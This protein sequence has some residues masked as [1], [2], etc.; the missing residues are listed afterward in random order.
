[1]KKCVNNLLV[2]LRLVVLQGVKAGFKWNNAAFRCVMLV[3]MLN[4]VVIHVSGEVANGIGMFSVSSTKMVAFAPGNLQ[5]HPKN[6]EWRFAENQYDIIGEDNKNISTDYDGWID[7]F[8]WSASDGSAK[9]GVSSSENNNDYVG[10]FV[11]WGKNQIGSDAPDTWRTMTMDEWCYLCNTRMKADSLRGLGRINGVAGL[12]LLPDNWTCPVGVT[13]DSY[14]VQRFTINEWSRLEA[15]GAVFLPCAGFRYGSDVNSVNSRPTYWSSTER[16]EGITAYYINLV[17]RKE[18]AYYLY[19]GLSV[20]LVKDVV[21]LDQDTHPIH[22]DTTTTKVTSTLGQTISKAVRINISDLLGSNI[23]I[24]GTSDNSAFEVVALENVSS[25]GQNLIVNYTPTAVTDGIETATIT[26]Y[27]ST[28]EGSTSFTMTGRHV[29]AE[30]AIISKIGDQWY[31]LPSDN[32]NATAVLVSVNDDANPT[33]GVTMAPENVKWSLR[34]PNNSAVD[35]FVLTNPNNQYLNVDAN[36]ALQMNTTYNNCEWQPVIDDLKEYQLTNAGNTKDLGVSQQKIF[37]TL[38]DNISDV[39]RLVS[40]YAETTKGVGVFSVS[41]TKQVT[42]SPGNLQYHPKN[43]EWRFAPSQLDYVGEE[44]NHW[45]NVMNPSYDGW[46][47][48]F[49]WSTEKT[50]FGLSTTSEDYTDGSFVDWGI[51]Q[52]SG[53]APN[54]WR[55]LTNDEWGYILNERPYASSLHGVAQVNGVN[56]LVL[57]PDNW[58]C[59]AGVTFKSG[60]HEGGQSSN[61]YADYQKIDVNEWSVLEAAGAVFLPAAGIRRWSDAPNHQAQYGRY[62]TASENGTKACYLYFLSNKAY[63]NSTGRNHA[64]SV[65][66]AQDLHPIQVD[67]TTTKVTSTLGQTISKAV[68][69]NISDLLGSNITIIGT[70]D[71]PAFTVVDL[72]NVSSGEQN[73]IINYT[74]TAVTDGIETA[75]ITLSCGTIEN[76]TSFTMTGRHLAQN[77]VIAAK[78]GNG[79]VAMTAKVINGTQVA[80]PIKVDNTET[81]TKATIAL[82]TC[83]YQLL[84]LKD[85]FE[86]NGTAVHLYSTQTQKVLNAS[87]SITTQTYLNTDATHDNAEKSDNAL[88]YEWQLVTEDLVHYTIIN[89]NT[90]NTEN[91][92]LGYS[93]STGEWGLY[94]SSN[95]V[96][97]EVFLLPIETTLTEKDIEV[98]EWGTNSMALRFGDAAP[99][100]MNVTLGET[101]TNVTLTNLNSSDIYLVD[102]LSG[103]TNNNHEVMVISYNGQGTFIRKPILVSGDVVSTNYSTLAPEHRDVVI[104]NGGKLNAGSAHVNFANIYVYPGGKLVLDNKSLGVKQQVYLRGGYSW[105]N[106]TTYALPEVYLNG[107]INFNGSGNMIYDYYIQNYKYYQFALP[108]SVPLANV[109]DEAGYDNFPVWVKHYN[110]ALRAADASATSW[111]WYYG[112]NFEAGVGYVIAAQPRR[113]DNVANRPL[114]II[115]FPL[116]N[117]AITQAE[118]NKSVATTAHGIDGYKAGSVTANNVGWNYVGNPFF[119]TWQGSIGHQQLQEHFVNDKWDGSYAWVDDQ[120]R[121]IT[122]MSP[123][124]DYDYDQYVAANAELRP[125]SPFFMQEV[126]DGGAGSINFAAANRLMKAPAQMLTDAPRELFVQIEIAANGVKDQTGLFVSESYSNDLD[127][128]DYEKL[129]GSASDKAKLWLMHEKRRMAFEAM[130]EQRATAPTALGFRAPQ[131]G[132]YT[133]SLNEQVSTTEGVLAVY[134]TDHELGITDHD[135]MYAAYEFESLAAKYNDTR[136]TIRLVLDDN[137]GGIATGVD[138]LDSKAEGI[139]KFIYQGNLYIYQDG[140]IYDVTGRQ[141]KSKIFKL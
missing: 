78:A 17:D 65:R 4:F 118:A 120:L 22:V 26:L 131:A 73:L 133:L 11:D 96:N 132:R 103:L 67:A 47:D 135:L 35:R 44:G 87:T 53:N 124:D 119:A 100:N 33:M 115:R 31:A 141:I 94:Q 111:E 27:S 130:T 37:G 3:V 14:K 69:I 6:D 91:R 40:I 32:P 90:E 25:G 45:D 77:F 46:L 19:T 127:L 89:S 48:L 10:D 55:T 49:G 79:W 21:R 64:Q 36:G 136:F 81:P 121:Y 1:M 72:E 68:R 85:R 43:Q 76:L 84:G 105:L 20:R 34:T 12:I 117:E 9:F 28:L 125:F 74:P 41:A 56:G 38:D 102:N 138:V 23:T 57:L 71:N 18:A 104:L 66:L 30:F 134:L 8:G 95:V 7:L 63:M 61:Y 97:Q 126:A 129:F 92:V 123:E 114:S 98:M 99:A 93:S 109:T 88:F 15:E 59:P 50:N 13:F 51:N 29:P 140:I 16:E 70:S 54:T 24:T 86:K 52:I 139:Y 75:T 42:F 107:T 106:Q 83:Q 101:T 110:G 5:Y 2:S 60:F 39:V 82:N 116:G 62:W 108:Y 112:D 122:V 113:V 128:D 80:I 58:T 137:T